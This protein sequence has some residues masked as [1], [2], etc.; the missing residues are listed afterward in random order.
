MKRLFFAVLIFSMALPVMAQN[1]ITTFI[2]VRHTEKSQDDPRDPSLSEAGV[3]RAQALKNLLSQA[4]INALYSTAYKRTRSTVQPIAEATGLEIQT[5]D[6]RSADFL[7]E[8]M[9]KYKGKTIVVSGHSN[10]TPLVANA[11]IGSRKFR[12]LADDD[13]SKVFVVSVSEIGKGT[14]TILTY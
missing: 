4:E 9:E 6:P 2:L 14:A 5:Y 12:Q 3:K 13:Y 10:T 8:I 1:E 11:L 7:K